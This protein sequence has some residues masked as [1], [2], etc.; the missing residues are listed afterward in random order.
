MKTCGGPNP[1]SDN[2][3]YPRGNKGLGVISKGSEQQCGR[4][5]VTC[6]AGSTANWGDLRSRLCIDRVQNVPLAA[7]LLSCGSSVP[8]LEVTGPCLTPVGA[9]GP[10]N[11]QVI[12]SSGTNK[13]LHFPAPWRLG[14]V[15]INHT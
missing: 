14:Q 2:V 11:A 1:P 5:A 4:G 12:P 8:D 9:A 13:I 10:Q 3:I 15:S 6:F 7:T